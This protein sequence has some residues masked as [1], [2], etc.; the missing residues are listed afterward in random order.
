MRKIRI[1]EH[2]SLDGVIQPGGRGEDRDNALRDWTAPFRRPA[3]AQALA[4]AQGR[5]FDLLL[6]LNCID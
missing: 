2:T 3:G 4:E 5:S 1:F 6:V